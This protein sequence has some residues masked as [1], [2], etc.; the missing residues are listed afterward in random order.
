M[1]IESFTRLIEND[2]SR[3]WPFTMDSASPLNSRKN[4]RVG[5]LPKGHGISGDQKGSIPNR[6]GSAPPSFDGSIAALRDLVTKQNSSTD[7]SVSGPSSCQPEEELLKHLAYLS[8]YYLNINLNPRLPPP[9]I[10]QQGRRLVCQNGGH[11][12]NQRLT[13]SNNFGSLSIPQNLLTTHEEEPKE[14]TSAQY[15]LDNH[16]GG[17]IVFM[18]GTDKLSLAENDGR[19]DELTQVY[20]ESF[21]STPSSAVHMSQTSNSTTTRE[22]LLQDSHAIPTSA[23]T[24][25]ATESKSDSADTCANVRTSNGH[26]ISSI[27][28]ADSPAD[29]SPTSKNADLEDRESAHVFRGPMIVEAEPRLA[30]LNISGSHESVN[31]KKKH[32]QIHSYERNNMP[33]YPQQ[34]TNCHLDGVQAQRM[35]SLYNG[36]EALFS[37]HPE[38][39]GMKPIMQNPGLMPTLYSTTAAMLTS[40]NPLY[41]NLQPSGSNSL[42]TPGGCIVHSPLYPQFISGYAPHNTFP[43]PLNGYP[44]LS[45]FNQAVSISTGQICPHF[46]NV[47]YL[48]KIYEQHALM[49]Q[50]FFSGPLQGQHIGQPSMDQTR[51]SIHCSQFEVRDVIQGQHD[52]SVSKEESNLAVFHSDGKFMHLA[53]GSL[54][55]SNARKGG[56][57]GSNYHVW[58]PNFDVMTQFLPSSSVLPGFPTAGTYPSMFR[59]NAKVSH[60]YLRNRGTYAA[61]KTQR[62][63]DCSDNFK[64]HS[65]LEALRASNGRKIELSDIAGQI[66][67]LS[68]DQHGSRFIQQSLE[69]SSAEEKESIFQEVLPHATKLTTDVF[70]NYVIQKLF[71]HGSPDQR[72]RLADQLTGQMLSLSLQMYGCRVIQKALEIIELNQKVQLAQELDGNVMRCVRDQNGNHVIQKCIECIPAEKIG[73][74]ISDFRGQVAT[75]S[76]HPYGCRV[77]QRVLEH[78]SD[79]RM[80]YDMVDEILESVCMLAQDQ[81]GNYVIQHILENRKPHERSQIISKLTGKLIHMS[82]HKYASNVIEKCLKFGDTSVQELLIEEIVGQPEENGNL[83]MMMKDQY[84]NYVVQ[85]ILEIGNDKQ[86]EIVLNCIRDNLQG[87][88]KYTYGKHIVVRYEQLSGSGLEQRL[89]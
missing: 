31:D 84:A 30:A 10:S 19:L 80:N 17:S 32:D 42:L 46:S 27:S 59:D 56:T 76:T 45:L 69:N 14:D 62:G 33:C 8:Y 39:Q 16:A 13:S 44:G 40:W 71:E 34:S 85:R 6:S 67:E 57:T 55:T 36:V 18:A 63:S 53:D 70:G 7:T 9:L 28:N 4:N 12:N 2:G 87:L 72:K 79:E 29:Y 82:Q 78:C 73:F 51:D 52:A 68:T 54:G 26:D 3:Q 49:L 23:H 81:Y 48:N 64:R 88:K 22:T 5:V 11:E 86:R 37:V 77:I 61:F 50:P 35:N 83:L 1:A 58:P 41:Q 15:S 60:D 20:D 47:Q 74:I 89:E 75:L 24:L 43:M 66:A 21:Q 38:S 65:I 25:Q